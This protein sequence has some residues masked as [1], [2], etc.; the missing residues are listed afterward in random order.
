MPRFFFF[1][2][3]KIKF[4]NLNWLQ[5]NLTENSYE[6]HGQFIFKLKSMWYSICSGLIFHMILFKF[7][8]ILIEI[9]SM[10]AHMIFN[11]LLF[12]YPHNS[13]KN[14][15]LQW[16]LIQSSSYMSLTFPFS[17]KKSDLISPQDKSLSFLSEMISHIHSWDRSGKHRCFIF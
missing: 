13:I 8:L 9:D 10:K 2:Q 12:N 5:L 15:I 3:F 17:F 14:Y 6:E 11:W 16:I 1:I 7:T 4:K